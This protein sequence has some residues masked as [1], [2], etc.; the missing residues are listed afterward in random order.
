VPGDLSFNEFYLPQ[1]IPFPRVEQIPRGFAERSGHLVHPQA[2]SAEGPGEF[3]IHRGL[4]SA[5]DSKRNKIQRRNWAG[6]WDGNSQF[7]R[8]IAIALND[9]I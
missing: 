3:P 9:I 2:Q 5:G 8:Y 1:E 6:V 4:A 7:I